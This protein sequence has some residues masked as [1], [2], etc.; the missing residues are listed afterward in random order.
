VR[1]LR[2]ALDAAEL[3]LS[4]QERIPRNRYRFLLH[5]LIELGPQAADPINDGLQL[6]RR[7]RGVRGRI[8][9]RRLDRHRPVTPTPVQAEPDVI[10]GPHRLQLAGKQAQRALLRLAPADIGRGN[11]Q[12]HVVDLGEATARVDTPTVGGTPG[13]DRG[14][15]QPKRVAGGS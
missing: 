6:R 8:P 9:A 11:P 2:A 10:T 15:E 14:D 3:P 12:A 7:W 5:Q 4:H 1:R 13:S